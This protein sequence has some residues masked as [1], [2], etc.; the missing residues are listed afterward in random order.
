M[1]GTA[2]LRSRTCVKRNAA[3]GARFKGLSLHFYI[4]R[5]IGYVSKRAW[6]HIRYVSK[7]VPPCHGT[8]LMISLILCLGNQSSED[9][10]YNFTI[11]SLAEE[12]LQR[13]N[14]SCGRPSDYNYILEFQEDLLSQESHLQLHLSICQEFK[15]QHIWR[16]QYFAAPSCCPEV[17]CFTLVWSNVKGLKL[18]KSIKAS[19]DVFFFF[20][21]E[22]LFLFGGFWDTTNLR[23]PACFGGPSHR[24][25]EKRQYFGRTCH[26]ICSSMLARQ[27]PNQKPEIPAFVVLPEL[28]CTW[29][30]Q[31]T[32]KRG[33]MHC[34]APASLVRGLGDESDQTLKRFERFIC[35]CSHAFLLTRSAWQKTTRNCPKLC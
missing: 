3:F 27:S 4:K 24:N 25:L 13:W 14:S 6:I 26:Q 19:M 9:C 28:G 11:L 10:N 34:A 5:G 33:W 8:P 32:A 22:L 30:G 1:G 20:F 31:S 29:C 35:V 18:T 2:S 17:L 15:S 23:M 21:S 16:W 12:I 7:P